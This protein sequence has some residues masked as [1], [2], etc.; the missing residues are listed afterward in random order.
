MTVTLVVL[1]FAIFILIDYFRRRKRVKVTDARMPMR[2]EPVTRTQSEYVCGFRL[3]AHIRYHPGH[4]WALRES[5]TLV[6]VGMDDL[7]GRFI[8]PAEG[9]SFPKR[10]TWIR[11]GQKVFTVL[12]NGSKV[13]LVSPIEGEVTTVNETVAKDPS[14]PGIDPYGEG[15]LLT[16]VSPDAETNFRNLLGGNLARQW[17]TEAAN[18]LRANVP[19]LA[20]AVAQGGGTVV[21]DSSIQPGDQ[22]WSELARELF[23]V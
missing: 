20:G 14:L 12:R 15:W 23:L 10:G 8:G 16:V 5:P 17:M 18:R 6:R 11:Q 22:T 9:I 19:A 13:D 4:T 7:A 3:P 21:S 1:T 2:G